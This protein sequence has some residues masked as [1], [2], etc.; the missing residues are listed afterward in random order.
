MVE[1]EGINYLGLLAEELS[2]QVNFGESLQLILFEFVHYLRFKQGFR[3]LEIE[4]DLALVSTEIWV[5]LERQRTI[6]YNVQLCQVDLLF[7]LQVRL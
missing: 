1:E 5:Q 6:F 2:F 3:E 7:F 4:C